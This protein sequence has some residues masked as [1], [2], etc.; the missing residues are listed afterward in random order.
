MAAYTT[1]NRLNRFF[2]NKTM[3]TII[4]ANSNAVSNS[5]KYETLK[6]EQPHEYVFN[7]EMNRPEKLN[8]MNNSLWR[9]IGEC[10]RA[11]SDDVNCR[12]IVLS[13]AGK[14]FSSGL[15]LSAIAQVFENAT[16]DGDV[17]RKA[18]SLKKFVSDF[19]ASFTALEK[20]PK[21]VIGAIHGACIGAAVDLITACDIRYCS[22]DT[23]FQIKEVDM[24]LA[25]D[26]GTLQRLPKV[27]GNQSTVREL[28]F[29]ARKFQSDEA[30]ELG[31]VSKVFPDRAAVLTAAIQL[32]TLISQKS[33]VAVQGTKINLNY[34]RDHPVDDA[35]DYMSTWNMAMLQTED[36]VASAS[37]VISKSKD[38]PTFS[39]L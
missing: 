23:W 13:G 30:L 5:Y 14:M 27:V 28:C 25:A 31:V 20:C 24:G 1:I 29:T 10:F 8:A 26:V 17:A 16:G 33:P 34:S 15:D 12:A 39:K 21:P 2:L 3:S 19:Q 38:P 37:A 11:L 32:A 22:Q 7:V 18:K 6:V 35:L 4:R 9:E 36:V